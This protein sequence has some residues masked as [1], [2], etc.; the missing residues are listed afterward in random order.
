MLLTNIR[1]IWTLLITWIECYLCDNTAFGGII[2][3]IIATHTLED[4]YVSWHNILNTDIIVIFYNFTLLFVYGEGLWIIHIFYEGRLIKKWK[5]N[6]L[7]NHRGIHG[8][9]EVIQCDTFHS[10]YISSRN[11]FGKE[12]LKKCICNFLVSWKKL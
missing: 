9:D 11:F 6:F 4:F 7:H 5:Y 3:L 12:S 2:G 1:G 8:R 10:C